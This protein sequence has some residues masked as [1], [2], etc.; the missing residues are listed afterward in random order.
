MYD[1]KV[2]I[3]HIK[4]VEMIEQLTYETYTILYTTIL[5][6]ISTVPLSKAVRSELDTLFSHSQQL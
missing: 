2:L 5:H 1:N 4:C 3:Y 6:T